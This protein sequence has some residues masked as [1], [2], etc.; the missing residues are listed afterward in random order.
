MKKP[1]I[2][3]SECVLCDICVELCPDVFIKNQA[4]YIEVA[5]CFSEYIE[6]HLNKN[7]YSSLNTDDSKKR[8]LIK[9][10][11]EDVNDIIK[12]CRGDCISWGEKTETENI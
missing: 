8:A 9:Y 4:G 3:I 12:S 11:E 5:E 2:D 1:V 10:I 6:N 7:G